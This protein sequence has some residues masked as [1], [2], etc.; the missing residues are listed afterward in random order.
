MNETWCSAESN[1]SGVVARS[2]ARSTP[3]SRNSSRTCCS[4]PQA[5]GRHGV[6]GRRRQ[7]AAHD[8]EQLA[9]LALG[10]P[11]EEADRAAGLANA[12]ELTRGDVV[13][14]RELHAEGGED[15]VEAAVLEGQLL[16]VARDP[17]D[18]DAELVRRR[19]AVSNSSGVKSRAVTRARAADARSATFPVP[20]ATSRTSWPG[21][22]PTRSS[23]F[24]ATS[25]VIAWATAGRS[26][27]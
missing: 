13:P 21:S 18:L 10:R 25:S 22:I 3:E 19:R 14:G 1:R 4:L 15:A 17:L 2:N 20:V 8:P 26:R 23:S 16:G 9:D 12:S 7:V 6:R 27:R 11:V 24:G 5:G